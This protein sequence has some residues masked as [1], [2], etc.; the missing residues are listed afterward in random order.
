MYLNEVDKTRSEQNMVENISICA[1]FNFVV[2]VYV[3]MRSLE[4]VLAKRFNHRKQLV[5]T[6]I[7]WW[8]EQEK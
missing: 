7:I 5:R 1:C 6:I 8:N 3:D 2:C 4:N